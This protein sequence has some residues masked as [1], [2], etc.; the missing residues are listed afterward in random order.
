VLIGD[1]FQSVCPATGTGLSKVLTDVQRLCRGHVPG[2]LETPGMGAEK[3]AAFYRDPEKTSSDRRSL[4][5]AEH[6]RR[7]ATDRSLKGW[8]RRQRDFAR[9]ALASLRDSR[10]RD[11]PTA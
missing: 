6:R 4:Q 10:Q 9:V 1:A 5:M 11:E 8:A 3:I 7:A 2:W